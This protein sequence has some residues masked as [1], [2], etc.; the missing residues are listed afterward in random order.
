MMFKQMK[1]KIIVLI[2]ENKLLPISTPSFIDTKLSSDM[3]IS[4]VSLATSVP[5]I[6]IATPAFAIFN[7]KASFIPSPVIATILPS[8]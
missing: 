8:F 5:V 2:L 4:A 6:P 3:T 1:K 7:A